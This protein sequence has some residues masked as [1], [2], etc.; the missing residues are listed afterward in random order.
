MIENALY[1]RLASYSAVS[2]LVADAVSPTTYRI[3][4]LVIPQHVQGEAAQ[5]PSIVYSKDSVERQVLFIGTN[6]V[7]RVSFQIDCYAVSHIAAL[8]LAAAVRSA[9]LDYAGVSAGVV[10]RASSLEN[11]FSAVDPEPGLYRVVQSWSIWHEE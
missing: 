9:L 4:P 2:A 7:V 10:I 3:Y 6:N 11:E 5:Q 1:A 8:T